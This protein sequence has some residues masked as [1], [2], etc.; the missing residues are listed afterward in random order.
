VRG[1][2]LVG[3]IFV[4]EVNDPLTSLVKQIDKEL[5][6]AGADRRPG[7]P[8][9]GVFIIF[10]NDKPGQADELRELVMCKEIKNV[11]LC[12][13]KGDS[14]RRYELAREADLTAVIFEN[15]RDV[16]VNIPL[17]KG[18]LTEKKSEEI[19]RAVIG[20]LPKKTP[21]PE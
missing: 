19:L 14:P 7:L 18:E 15:H 4:R 2:E 11:V 13:F 16:K 10:C 12:A 9:L 6:T 21:P 20:V 1:Y 5:E 17:K 8:K 3:L